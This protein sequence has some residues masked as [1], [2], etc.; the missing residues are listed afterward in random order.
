M[1]KCS[2][3]NFEYTCKLN[4]KKISVQRNIFLGVASET[5][6]KSKTTSIMAFITDDLFIF[7][8][9]PHVN[10]CHICYVLKG[11]KNK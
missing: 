8:C 6:K 5:K 1:A 3:I 11:K 7:Q 2:E 4:H 10:H 9:I